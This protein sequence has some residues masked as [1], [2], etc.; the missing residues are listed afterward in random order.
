MDIILQKQG[1]GWFVRQAIAYGTI[2]VYAKHYKDDSGVEHID[3]KQTLSGGFGGTTEDRTLDWVPRTH[4]DSIF[5]AVIGK[6]RRIDVEDIDD[7]FLKQNWSPDVIE[8]GAIHTFV[9]SDTTK[10]QLSWTAEQTWGFED[11]NGDRRYAR[12]VKF[13]ES[14]GARVDAMM[15]YDYYGPNVARGWFG[16]F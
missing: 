5:G 9:E 16:I 12:H 3:I 4:E 7:E 11:I 13:L 6:S 14:D 15:V 1:V 8:H 2:T 10:N